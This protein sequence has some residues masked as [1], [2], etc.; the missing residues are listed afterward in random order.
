MSQFVL[1]PAGLAERGRGKTVVYRSQSA[2][3]M[4]R[5]IASAWRVSQSAVQRQR[6]VTAMLTIGTYAFLPLDGSN[7]K[8]LRF[9]HVEVNASAES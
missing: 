5:V 7:V 4:W 6:R 9:Q 2:A 3:L 8:S 1:R